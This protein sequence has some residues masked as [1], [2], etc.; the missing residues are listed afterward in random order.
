MTGSARGLRRLLT[1]DAGL[2]AA[3]QTNNLESL[4]RLKFADSLKNAFI[5]SARDF[6]SVLNRIFPNIAGLPINLPVVHTESQT[7][8]IGAALAEALTICTGMAERISRQGKQRAR[9][10]RPLIPH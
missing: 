6:Y 4:R 9:Y 3:F 7:I 2:I 1:V 8:L 5:S 10:I